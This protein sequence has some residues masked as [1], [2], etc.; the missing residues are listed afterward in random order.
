MKNDVLNTVTKIIT[1]MEM[2]VPDMKHVHAEGVTTVILERLTAHVCVET[3]DAHDVRVTLE[4]LQKDTNSVYVHQPKKTLRLFEP[5]PELTTRWLCA[6]V[7]KPANDAAN[8]S[9]RVSVFVPKGTALQVANI[10]G[11][12]HIGDVEGAVTITTAG[13]HHVTLGHVLATHIDAQGTGSVHCDFVQDTLTIATQQGPV[14]VKDGIVQ[15]LH[16]EATGSAVKYGGTAACADITA[17]QASVTATE[18]CARLKVAADN[19]SRVVVCQG[20]LETLD[21]YATKKSR[22]TFTGTAKNI[23]CDHDKTSAICT[24]KIPSE[25]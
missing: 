12:V 3:H 18:V 23:W 21:V 8:S 13:T 9:L 19:K 2:E 5:V 17:S 10:L 7:N 16:I 4:G 6:L 22:V 24:P 25:S 1:G 11:P 15:N 20:E 14:E